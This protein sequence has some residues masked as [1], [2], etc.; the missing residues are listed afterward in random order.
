[1]VE[2]NVKRGLFVRAIEAGCGI[3]LGIVVV[4]GAILFGTVLGSLNAEANLR[5]S[6]EAHERAREA[7]L[8]TMRKVITQKTQLPAAA[9][10]DL[11]TLLPE[12]VA[13]RQGGSVFKSVSEKYPELTLDLYKDISRSIESERHQFLNEQEELFDVK[14]EHDALL[15]SVVGGTVCAIAGRRPIPVITV[16]SDEAKEIVK[17]GVDNDTDLGLA[18]PTK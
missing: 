13:G 12:V 16:S 17:T 14:R 5:S 10:A 18:K 2:L 3:I 6:I 11:L 9:K 7:H 4:V 8:D 15:R 1:V